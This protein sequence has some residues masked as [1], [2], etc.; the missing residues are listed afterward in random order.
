MLVVIL[1]AATLCSCQNVE[2]SP[3]LN[4]SAPEDINI[5]DSLGREITIPSSP[6]KI[7]SLAASNTEILFAINAY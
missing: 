4:P 2:N 3:Y 7:V 1:I 6:E 5:T